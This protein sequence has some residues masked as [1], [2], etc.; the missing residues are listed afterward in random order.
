[1][2]IKFL[3]NCLKQRKEKVVDTYDV[4]IAMIGGGSI[5]LANKPWDEV[6]L[7]QNMLHKQEPTIVVSAQED[8]TRSLCIATHN[9]C[10]IK[11]DKHES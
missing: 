10:F 5:V 11:A 3:A 8:R 9:I 1:M 7:L 6:A 2:W 4:T